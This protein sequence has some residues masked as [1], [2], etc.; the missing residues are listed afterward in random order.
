MYEYVFGLNFTLFSTTNSQW[1]LHSYR[2]KVTSLEGQKN[3]VKMLKFKVFRL[4][5]RVRTREESARQGKLH[6]W[7]VNSQGSVWYD[8]TLDEPDPN[9]GATNARLN[10]NSFNPLP[11]Q[12]GSLDEWVA[13]PLRLLSLL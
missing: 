2:N 13:I 8:I 10:A 12:G 4:D 3:S 1:L 11:D 7:I 6:G 9:T 5:L